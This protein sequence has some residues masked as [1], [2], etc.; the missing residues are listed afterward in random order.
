MSVVQAI[1]FSYHSHSHGFEHYYKPGLLIGFAEAYHA[2]RHAWTT[3][4]PKIGEFGVTGKYLERLWH[5]TSAPP[6][7]AVVWGR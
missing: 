3:V 6:A 5:Y 1:T 4:E 2:Q 7:V